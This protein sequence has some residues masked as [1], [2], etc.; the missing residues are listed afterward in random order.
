MSTSKHSIAE[1]QAEFAWRLLR[2]RLSATPE[3]ESLILSP[4]SLAVSLAMTL[5]GAKGHT[6]DEIAVAIAGGM[7]SHPIADLN[8]LPTGLNLTPTGFD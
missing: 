3:G 2:E 8:T 4:L 1:A 7:S 6:A 5:T